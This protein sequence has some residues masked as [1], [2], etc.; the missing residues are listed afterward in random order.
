MNIEQARQEIQKQKE[1]P[2]LSPNVQ[3]ILDACENPDINHGSFA[4]VLSESP[5][6]SARLLGLANSA[7]FGQQGRVHSLTHAISVLGLVTVRSVAVGLALSGVFKVDDCRHFRADRYWLSAITTALM[8]SQLNAQVAEAVRPPNDSVYMAGL[9]HNIGLLALVYLHPEKMNRALA[10]YEAD[11]S[12]KLADHVRDELGIDQYQA[13]VWLG[14]KWHLPRDLLLVMEFHYDRTYRGDHWPLVL[15]EG[16]SAQWANRIVEGAETVA[17][18]PGELEP[19]GLSPESVGR[20]IDR[21][22]DKLEGARELA[23]QF[24]K[25]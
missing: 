24:A 3:R 15:L 23:G 12:R 6:I 16:L 18:D 4:D 19:L 22:R 5:T 8:A 1:L 9:L 21:I 25:A 10:A 13:G 14:S 20:V 2:T 7:F 17:G 11:P